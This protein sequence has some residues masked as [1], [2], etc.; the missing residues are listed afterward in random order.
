MGETKLDFDVSA[1]GGDCDA[2]RNIIEGAGGGNRIAVIE[3]SESGY[4]SGVTEKTK[5]NRETREEN[6]EEQFEKRGGDDEGEEKENKK[7]K[8]EDEY[9]GSW[10]S[11]RDR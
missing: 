3:I 10:N 9:R 6:I 1:E 4:G 8:S 11:P 2:A 7:P 5:M